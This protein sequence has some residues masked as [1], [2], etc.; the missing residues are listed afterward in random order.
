MKDKLFLHLFKGRLS[1]THSLQGLKLYTPLYLAIAESTDRGVIHEQDKVQRF[2]L[3]SV[4][5]RIQSLGAY[6]KLI[7]T[8]S[9]WRPDLKSHRSSLLG[10]ST[11]LSTMRTV[12][13]MVLP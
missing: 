11:G 1:H 10:F 8:T 6:G 4:Q 13:D 7:Q 12:S 2:E 9:V 3:I 5:I